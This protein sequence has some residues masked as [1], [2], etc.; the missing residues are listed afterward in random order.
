MI[1]LSV[2]ILWISSFPYGRYHQIEIYSAASNSNDH[3]TTHITEFR[4]RKIQFNEWIIIFEYLTVSWFIID[5]FVRFIVSP[6]KKLFFFNFDN[7]ID[8]MSSI[9]ALMNT[10]LQYFLHSNKKFFELQNIQV[11]RVF[12]LFRLLNYHSGL[13]VIFRFFFFLFNDFIHSFDR[14]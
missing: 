11:I 6:Q 5:L 7:Y 4:I 10:I 8:I 14:L 13:K 9:F 3:S 1:V 2:A 12:R